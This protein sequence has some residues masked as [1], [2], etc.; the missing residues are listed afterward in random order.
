MSALAALAALPLLVVETGAAP[1]WCDEARALLEA[2]P[3]SGDEAWPRYLAVA[4]KLPRE[5]DAVLEDARRR[6]GE[7]GGMQGAF[8]ALSLALDDGCRELPV[9]TAG[10]GAAAQVQDI[11]A[12]D[13]RFRGAR[14]ERSVVDEWMAR[15][16]SWLEQVFESQLMRSYAGASRAV[17]LTGLALFVAFV[18]VRLWRARVKGR[19]ERATTERAAQIERERRLAFAEHR[20]EA[21]LLLDE[22]DLRGALRAGQLALLARIGEV[23]ERA[24][25]PA[26][27]N[28]EVLRRLEEPRRLVVEPPLARFEQAFY[29]GEEL[30]PAFVVGFLA[31]VDRA[32]R[33]LG[34][35]A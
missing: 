3:S 24:V 4:E 16:A 10:A 6:A 7:A 8:L 35:A 1:A 25:T 14:A 34:D 18:A 32:A 13:E 28:R 22:G 15:L 9:A 5:A 27:T 23:D 17:Y 20:R 11:L 30:A 31:E 26:R 21:D 33:A 12:R 19:G 29:G 2:A